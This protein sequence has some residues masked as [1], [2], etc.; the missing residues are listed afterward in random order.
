MG[1][2]G[3]ISNPNF[4]TD[5]IPMNEKE[6]ARLF[7]S[8]GREGTAKGTFKKTP[9]GNCPSWRP[10][11]VEKAASIQDAKGLRRVKSTVEFP[12]ILVQL[13]GWCRYRIRLMSE[14]NPEDA[15]LCVLYFLSFVFLYLDPMCV[16]FPN[17]L[18]DHATRDDVEFELA[19]VFRNVD[20]TIKKTG[21]RDGFVFL[22]HHPTAQRLA[23]DF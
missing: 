7:A 1:F 13:R 9:S 5:R 14:P 20:K 22:T 2:K 4:V 8:M 21:R 12:V 10:G 11:A 6:A 15:H 23:V 19:R 18:R 3:E 16:F 17:I